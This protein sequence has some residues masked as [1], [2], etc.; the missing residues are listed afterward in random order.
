MGASSKEEEWQPNLRALPPYAVHTETS[1][2]YL[3]AK[4]KGRRKLGMVGDNS[5]HS[6][7]AWRCCGLCWTR[8]LAP[9]RGR[10]RG[11]RQRDGTVG[12]AGERHHLLARIQVR[13]RYLIAGLHQRQDA[14]YRQRRGEDV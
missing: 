5:C 11:C 10:W 6:H 14:R 7:R 3:S 4:C 8:P 12:E 13:P 9:W 1:I 2:P